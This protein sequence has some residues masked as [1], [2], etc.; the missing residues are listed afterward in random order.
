MWNYNSK[1]DNVHIQK[2]NES[3]FHNLDSSKQIFAH[4]FRSDILPEKSLM[5]S[6]INV[7]IE[8]TR[9]IYSFFQ[10]NTRSMYMTLTS[11]H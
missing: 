4:I 5:S 7:N 11:S 9:I 1:S 2:K 3:A 10:G 8:N 6:V